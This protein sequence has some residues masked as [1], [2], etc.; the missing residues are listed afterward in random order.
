MG[1]GV[2]V[3]ELA[4]YIHVPFCLKKCHYCDF[5]SFPY[6]QDLVQS[7]LAGL[8]RELGLYFQLLAGKRVKTIYFGGGTP[9]CLKPRELAALFALI[10]RHVPVE[11]I[12][13]VTIECNPGTISRE[14]LTV[15][16]GAG[17]NRISLG[18]QAL[19]D[20]HLA[21]LGRIHRTADVY[22]SY[23]LL[24]REGFANIGFDLIF[25][26][27]GQ[28]LD[29]WEDTLK[30]VIALAPEHISTYNLVFEEGTPFHR[31][32]EE[33]KL[34]P[35]AE[36]LDAAMYRLALEMLPA[37]GYQ[38]YEIA[39][40]AQRNRECRHNMTYWR[41]EPYLG[42]GPG[43]HSYD[44]GRRRWANESSLDKYLA[45]LERGRVPVA[46]REELTLEL[47]QAETVILGLRLCQGVERKGFQKRFRQDLF[48]IYADNLERLAQQDLLEVIPQGIRL[49][50]KG[51]FFANRVFLEFL[52]A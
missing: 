9:S 46:T 48:A 4:L 52:P 50:K 43:A 24:R 16:K 33:G 2:K 17:V 27:P 12:K 51:L 13:E 36:E 37:A 25:A 15:F 21:R 8:E 42:L 14:R 34:I 28:T 35:P 7:Y 10:Y 40:F 26:L 3:Q 6:G 31:W 18:V 30:K 5:V 20:E 32:R 29:Q 1:R 11:Y 39:N 22:K 44:G 23:D 41:N 19:Q 45:A 49:T 47:E 38:Q